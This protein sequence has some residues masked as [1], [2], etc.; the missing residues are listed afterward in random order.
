[1]CKNSKTL[2]YFNVESGTD[3]DLAMEPLNNSIYSISSYDDYDGEEPNPASFVNVCQES[4]YNCE[5]NHHSPAQPKNQSIDEEAYC[6]TKDN[7]NH[8]HSI[9]N[10]PNPTQNTQNN[11][12]A[13]ENTEFTLQYQMQQNNMLMQHLIGISTTLTNLLERHVTAT[14]KMTQIMERQSRRKDFNS[15]MQRRRENRTKTRMKKF[16]EF[17]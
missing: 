6:E 4:V 17:F 11:P 16:Y 10:I 5:A 8:L 3:D 9:L 13:S 1:M 15:F 12:D 14:E 7:K 2:G